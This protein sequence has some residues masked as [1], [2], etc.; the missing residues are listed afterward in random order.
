MLLKFKGKEIDVNI[1]GD[2]GGT[3]LHVAAYHDHAEC[4]KLLVSKKMW[5]CDEYN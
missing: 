5:N 1:T 4:A 3:A 2:R